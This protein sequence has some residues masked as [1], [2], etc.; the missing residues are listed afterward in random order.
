MNN[1]NSNISILLKITI[2]MLI[3]PLAVNSQ[4]GQISNL[5]VVNGFRI[6]KFNDPITKHINNLVIDTS[7][8][9]N[10]NIK[11]YTYKKKEDITIS[12]LPVL[13]LKVDF[14]YGKLYHINISIDK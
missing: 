9:R 10:I 11:S 8:K 7:F 3:L 2:L 12:N 13:C 14:L 4:T 1:N 6:F 5:D